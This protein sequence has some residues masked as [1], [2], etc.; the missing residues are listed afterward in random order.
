MILATVNMGRRLDI[1]LVSTIFAFIGCGGS[2]NPPAP[3]GSS[4][5]G[6]TITGRERIGWTQTAETPGD[7][8][9][10]RYA[11]YVDGQRRVLEGE[12]CSTGSGGTVAD[13][14]APLPGLSPGSHT[15]ELVS[16]VMSGGE[17]LESART[18]VLRIT[19]AGA[20]AQTDGRIVEGGEFQSSD[21]IAL[22]AEI[23]ARD[24]DQPTDLAVADDGRV[25]V[26]ERGGRLRIIPEESP[27][28]VNHDN[29]LVDLGAIPRAAALLS[30]ALTPDFG[31]SGL[32]YV[33]YVSAHGDQPVL[34]IARLREVRGL[35][36]QPAIIGSYP[37]AS[38]EVPAIVRFSPDGHLHIGIGA[39]TN[40]SEAHDLATVSG[41]I[42]RL[43]PDGTTP[44]DNRAQSPIL[45]A[46]HKDPRGLAWLGHDHSLWEVERGDRGDEINRIRSGANYG[47]PGAAE[48]VDYP[49]STPPSLVLR[50][51]SDV[52]GVTTVADETSPFFGELIVSTHADGDLLR[53]T[54]NPDGLPTFRSRLLQGRFGRVAQVA[55][56]GNGALYFIT[57]SEES[58]ETVRDVLVRVSVRVRRPHNSAN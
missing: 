24:L 30:V 28:R 6:D 3:G 29:L 12:T 35:L 56:G 41:K 52:S 1:T 53:F 9:A 57:D 42:L 44:S 17:V 21:G 16:F 38:G 31:S 36:G 49:G 14:S 55:A 5:N 11:L 2:N 50:A 25:F 18:P 47:W 51:G 8:A 10:Y 39:G 13:C 15:L 27:A 58:P 34:Q 40:P 32:L 37:L 22:V 46:G 33:A 45:S 43:R 54:M 20:I 7:L 26:A 19:V 48:R 4:G 23:L